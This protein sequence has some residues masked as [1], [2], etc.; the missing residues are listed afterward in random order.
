MTAS[1]IKFTARETETAISAASE[2]AR[3]LT[4]TELSAAA[5]ADLAT[6]P[7][8]RSE[9]A[10][11]AAAL[12]AEASFEPDRP[13]RDH[14]RVGDPLYSDQADVERRHADV[15]LQ[16]DQAES[17]GRIA[18]GLEA[19]NQH[20]VPAE[21][22]TALAYLL[23]TPVAIETAG[24]KTASALGRVVGAI[25]ALTEA[26]AATGV[27]LRTELASL[28]NLAYDQRVS[29]DRL[30]DAVEDLV[31][32]RRRGRVWST[33]VMAAQTSVGV[34][35]GAGVLA[36]FGDGWGFPSWL[37]GA[38]A[39]YGGLIAVIAV[40]MAFIERPPTTWPVWARRSHLTSWK[41]RLESWKARWLTD[42]APVVVLEDPAPGA[43][44]DVNDPTVPSGR[45]GLPSWMEDWVPPPA[46]SQSTDQPGVT[47]S[48][49]SGVNTRTD[50]H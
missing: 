2:T 40:A 10:A 21:V 11:E 43:L 12:I 30:A 37:A 48:A 14:H 49:A 50:Q 42:D 5:P 13:G 23:H 29:A 22:S 26:T 46:A 20:P 9:L 47:P 28:G 27:D 31:A 19:A 4:E 35:V 39:V 17:L 24:Q 7:S 44:L 38:C 1:A 18:A 45:Y 16:L 3:P 6:D 8:G 36:R 34:L 25:D 41:P 32:E 33:S 15:L